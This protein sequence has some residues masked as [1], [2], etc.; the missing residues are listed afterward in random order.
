VTDL[1][2]EEIAQ[3]ERDYDRETRE[4]ERRDAA[5]L[6]P[7]WFKEADGRGGL[8]G[9]RLAYWQS[10]ARFP[11]A[12]AGRRSGKTIL[13]QAKL[14]SR[15][16]DVKPWPDA[17]YFF[18]GPTEGQAKEIGWQ[19]M[20][21]LIQNGPRASRIHKINYSD[22]IITVDLWF[23]KDEKKYYRSS[24]HIIG[25]DKPQRMEG[26]GWDGGVGDERADWKAG[27]WAANMRP[28]LADRKGFCYIIGVPDF[29]GPSSQEFKD[30]FELGL[31]KEQG[32]ESFTWPSVEVMDPAEVEAARKDTPPNIFRQEYEASFESAP[33]R[34]YPDF[35]R[36][37]HVKEFDYNPNAALFI[38]CDFNRVHH[39]WGA[40]QYYDGMYHIL[41]DLYLHNGTV[42]AMCNLA[43]DYIA[44]VEAKNVVFFGDYSGE[45]K[46]SEATDS[47][48][49][50]I[51]K[52]IKALYSYEVQPPI[53]DRLE[54]VNK[55]ILNAASEVRLRVRPQA[56][57]HIADFENVTRP[58]A[59]S[60]EGGKNGELTHASS[61]F[62][63][64]VVQNSKKKGQPFFIA[65][66]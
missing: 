1:A 4:Q 50:Q 17:R 45:Q 12:A 32:Y 21:D 2:S 64:M 44:K 24:F 27:L 59:Y 47:A 43:K 56:K 65:F 40:Y 20:L 42:E 57:N 7:P 22:L 41:D 8:S 13:S 28:A 34:A 51:K 48:W 16:W 19:R 58:M 62:G 66:T 30:Q 9:Q 61:A 39:N 63:Y 31:R 14:E 11:L 33:G 49:G 35:T 6:N 55:Q 18:A 3:F 29:E 52:N 54:E 15:I 10:M 37:I 60:G 23:N 53:A 5:R 38:S 46:R 36:T 25:L 26:V